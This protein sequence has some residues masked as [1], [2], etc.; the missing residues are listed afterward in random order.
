MALPLGVA[1]L[2]CSPASPSPAQ[3]CTLPLGSW[4]ARTPRSSD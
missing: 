3:I 2:G 1:R 4:A